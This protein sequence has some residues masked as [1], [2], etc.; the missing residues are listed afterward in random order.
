MNLS[1]LAS[2]Q[3]KK[4][5]LTK[6]KSTKT[7]NETSTAKVKP[8]EGA[9]QPAKAVQADKPRKVNLTVNVE[10]MNCKPL[11]HSAS[12][13]SNRFSSQRESPLKQVPVEA[14]AGGCETR[15]TP[16]KEN[17]PI[18]EFCKENMSE[19]TYCVQKTH[20]SRE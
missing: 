20:P 10:D 13:E 3:E 17:Y 7:L 12:I 19:A 15:I 11:R 2:E 1:K 4:A 16:F 8:A 14:S 5:A 9:E 18:I 6:K